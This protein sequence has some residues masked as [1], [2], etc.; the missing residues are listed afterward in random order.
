MQIVINA[1]GQGT[2]L[3]PISTKENPKQFCN[4]ILN[5]SL[6]QLTFHRLT[7]NFSKDQI[8]IS[9]SQDY[10]ELVKQQLPEI[11]VKQILLEPERRDTFPAVIAHSALVASKT[12]TQESIIF[13][14]SDQY[15]APDKSIENHNQALLKIDQELQAENFDLMVVGIK[16][17]FASTNYGY[18]Q[19]ATSDIK[20]SFEKGVEVSQFKE[21]PNLE[22][23]EHFLVE[24][25]FFWNF[26]SFS[27]KY[28]NLLK[29]LNENK[30]ESLP[31]LKNI[32]QKKKIDLED[33]KNL[34]KTSFDYAVLEKVKNLGMVA[35]ELQVWDDIGNFD[36]LYNYLP[37]VI[38]DKE[39]YKIEEKLNINHYQI[40]GKGNKVKIS[41]K[42]KKVA[43]VGVSDLMLIETK[44]G[45]LVIDPKYSNLVKNVANY[46]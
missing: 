39:A 15:I 2:R 12:S 31:F 37:N 23:A 7:K 42:N 13:I 19:I 45:I 11:D 16:P 14:N 18:I 10:F 35:M 29:I 25:N 9:T 26:G 30:P 28:D 17:T 1:G 43:F 36:T 46:F 41:D 8:W 34:E 32:F 6:L 20:E 40:K 5:S 24:K 4:L 21:K 33:F 38:S 3:W 22:T 44:D 27:F